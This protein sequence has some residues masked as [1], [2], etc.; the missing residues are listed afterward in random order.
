MTLPEGGRAIAEPSSVASPEGGAAIV[1]TA[2]DAFGSVE[3]VINNAGQIR[4]APFDEMSVDDFDAVKVERWR[5][6]VGGH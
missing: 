1:G 4:N 2:I 5:G 6:G 3:I